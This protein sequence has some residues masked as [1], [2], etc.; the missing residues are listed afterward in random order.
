MSGLSPRWKEKRMQEEIYKQSFKHVKD[1]SNGLRVIALFR[2]VCPG[3]SAEL[4]ITLSA[5]ISPVSTD[6]T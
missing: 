3:I 2:A 6:L 4:P 1:S 5:V